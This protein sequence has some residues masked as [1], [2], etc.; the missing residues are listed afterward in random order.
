MEDAVPTSALAVVKAGFTAALAHLQALQET[1]L[2]SVLER[3]KLATRGKLSDLAS[4][5]RD[6]EKLMAEHELS[7]LVAREVTQLNDPELELQLGRVQRR[8]NA[9]IAIVLDTMERCCK[10]ESSTMEEARLQVLEWEGNMRKKDLNTRGGPLAQATCIEKNEQHQ[11]EID[12]SAARLEG[13]RSA[14]AALRKQQ[15]DLKQSVSAPA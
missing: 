15:E 4:S 1:T 12:A 2:Q 5:K 9:V 10:D 13:M 7:F 14:M 6:C 3:R 11:A 8:S